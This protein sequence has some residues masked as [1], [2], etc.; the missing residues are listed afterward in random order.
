MTGGRTRPTD[1]DLE[2]EVL[3]STTSTWSKPRAACPAA[4]KAGAAEPAQPARSR[5]TSR[6]RPRSV[7]ATT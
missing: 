1:E 7:S 6:R 5:E 4:R 2:I 3:V